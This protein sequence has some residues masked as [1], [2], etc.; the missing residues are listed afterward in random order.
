MRPVARAGKT[1]SVPGE[2]DIG[3]DDGQM[4]PEHFGKGTK[5]RGW[6]GFTHKGVHFKELN[7]CQQVDAMG[8]ATA[9]V[10]LMLALGYQPLP[11]RDPGSLVQVWERREPGTAPDA[12]SGP[13]LA[14][15]ADATHNVFSSLGAISPGKY[16]L[17]D[18]RGAQE[19][20][21]CY[22]Q[23][24][25]FSDL[26]IQSVLGRGVRP[27]DV[28]SVSGAASPVW[29]SYR[30]WQSRYGGS[31]AAIGEPLGLATT[32]SE[33]VGM[34]LR[35][36]GVLL[37]G[38]QLPLPFTENVADA[39]YLMEPNIAA[40]SRQN[41][42]FFGVGRLRAGVTPAQSQ[43]A[44]TVVAQRQEQRFR[45][46]RHKRP[47]VEGLEAI[48][49]APERQTMG[50]LVLGVVFVFLV[51]C[52]DLAILMGA[53]GQQRQRE[54]AIRAA[55]GASL[56]RL[57]YEV[58]AEKSLL[59]LVSL[60]LGV[61]FAAMLLRVL[62]QLLPAAGLGPPLLHP[63]PLNLAVLLGFASFTLVATLVWSALLVFAS[64]GPQRARGL[65]ARAADRGTPATNRLFLSASSC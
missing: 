38:V 19:V 20:P 63:P 9:L 27:D 13:D 52:V 30:L 46:D 41:T 37:P 24:G 3:T 48:A 51:G 25:I 42:V 12:I 31:P 55:L 10:S 14:E 17:V 11:L 58:A 32:P 1:F 16:W 34:N 49:Q 47:V 33:H 18:R 28:P 15:F 22:I 45:I 53:E 8:A 39:W 2:H 35:I 5:G 54:I 7:N 43:S 65:P 29:I 36:A 61:V 23:A 21:T 6:Y 50:L 59:T 62:A 64:N 57:W 26:G 4:Y 40:R 60:G 56:R 44:L